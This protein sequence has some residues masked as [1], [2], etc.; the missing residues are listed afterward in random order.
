MKVT[1]LKKYCRTGMTQNRGV[2]LPLEMEA[3]LC[4]ATEHAHFY[5]H[6]Q[7]L[8]GK[9]ESVADPNWKK[10]WCIY[11]IQLWSSHVFTVHSFHGHACIEQVQCTYSTLCVHK[12]V[13]RLR[14]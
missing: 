14:L 12:N 8:L 6:A 10:R 3:K 13:Y 9:V 11:Y 2:A 1:Q 4:N 7:F 5:R